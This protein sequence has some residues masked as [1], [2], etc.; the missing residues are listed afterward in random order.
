MY[1]NIVYHSSKHEPL[2]PSYISEKVITL[3]DGRHLF[4]D[5]YLI[6]EVTNCEKKYYSAKKNVKN[7]VLDPDLNENN[8]SAPNM[9]SVIWDPYSKHFK[10]WYTIEDA[11]IST[12]LAISDNGVDWFKPIIINKKKEIGYLPCCSE[13][14][15][16]YKNYKGSNNFLH[17][18]GG[19]KNGKG[20]GSATQI[21]DRKENNRNKLFKM[22]WGHCHNLHICTSKDGINWELSEEKTG[23]GGGSPW[24]LCYNPFKK[25]YLYTF[26]DNLPHVN[27]TRV[28][29]F[30]EVENLTD[31]WPQWNIQEAYGGRGF[32]NIKKE[33][34][35]IAV[36]AD[37]YDI[38]VSKRIPGIYCNVIIPYESISLFLMSVFQGEHSVRN[39]SVEIY[40]GY[41]RDGIQYTRPIK[42]RK[43]FICE[44][45]EKNKFKK[46]S[47]LVTC[48]GN[49]LFVDEKIYIYVLNYNQILKQ[50]NTYLYTLRRDGFASI[51]NINNKEAILL[52][53]PL[54]ING[55]YLFVNFD[56]ETNGYL[57]VELLDENNN[58][59]E[60]YS[61]NESNIIKQ[62]STKIKINWIKSNK[63]NKEKHQTI[64]IKFYFIGSL[65]S[66]WFSENETGESNG[67]IGNG[68]PDYEYYTDSKE[69]DKLNIKCFSN[70]EI[71]F[72]KRMEKNLKT[73]KVIY[74][75]DDMAV[76]INNYGLHDNKLGI[77]VSY[78]NNKGKDKTIDINLTKQE[79]VKKPNVK[80]I[81]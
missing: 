47:Y 75:L 57:Y 76:K 63:I 26:R 54:I 13:C 3:K 37:K 28:N 2:V 29:R 6:H 79:H 55:E 62:N 53:K 10:M 70:I 8:F 12:K 23:W 38:T 65:Y 67:F 64:K 59:L 43:P 14:K 24:Y 73:E 27:M 11:P 32:T 71:T 39:K 74:C 4:V 66:F 21:I 33:D 17:T 81:L 7:P 25:K 1:N 45:K 49:I 31:K 20:R 19:C 77:K 68:G 36:V 35:Q 34:P 9:D 60:T 16:K 18:L 52:T 58:I 40:L 48:G 78:T 15:N 69:T 46:E 5:D 42:D 50:V 22:V 61:K 56:N 44:S 72:Q 30:K 80:L 51:T 41:S